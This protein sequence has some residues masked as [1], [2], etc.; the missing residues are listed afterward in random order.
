[1]AATRN[2]KGFS[3]IEVMIAVVLVGLSITALA[4]ATNSFTQA[5]GVGADLSTA[6]FLI[7][8]IRELTTLLP[9][10]DPPGMSWTTFGPEEGSLASYDDVDDFDNATFSPPIN[11]SRGTLNDL[12]GFTQQVT[13]QNISATSFD[14]VATDRSTDFV[15]ITVNIHQGGQLI[16]STSWIRARY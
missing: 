1:M 10:V 7:E 6:E 13:V 3:L 11:A 2:C 9:V 5:N 12:A 16:T 4:V 8:Q 14:T 15:R